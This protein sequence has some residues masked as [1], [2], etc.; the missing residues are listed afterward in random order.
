MRPELQGSSDI[1]RA[2]RRVRRRPRTFAAE[3][4]S[5]H[6]SMP[7]RPRPG[8]SAAS[9]VGAVLTFAAAPA[10][11]LPQAGHFQPIGNEF[12]VHAHV[13][14]NQFWGRVDIRDDGS[15]IGFAYAN[16]QDP[17]ARQFDASGSP[18]TGYLNCNPSLN[19]HVQD[20]PE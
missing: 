9:R 7:T 13:N 20:A 16:G 8:M 18:V 14:Y 3:N 11:A 12:V 5:L 6:E 4:S 19:V 17:A 1:L 10:A 15:L 2:K